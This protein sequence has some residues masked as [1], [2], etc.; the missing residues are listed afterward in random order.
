MYKLVSGVATSTKFTTFPPYYYLY[1][2]QSGQLLL[3]VYIK[4]CVAGSVVD[5]RLHTL[6]P[7][8]F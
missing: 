6:D 1:R 5:C 4:L 8:G 3:A 2:H 7:S